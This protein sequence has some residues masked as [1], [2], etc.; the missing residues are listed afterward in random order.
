MKRLT[1]RQA[2][3][4]EFGKRASKDDWQKQALGYSLEIRKFE[5][6]LYWKRATYFWA[7]I[8]ATFAGYFALFGKTEKDASFAALVLACLGAL[9]SKTWVLANRGSKFWQLNWETHVDALEPES[10]GPLYQTVIAAQR[11]DRKSGTEP[12]PFSVSKLN[13]LLSQFVT[14]VWYLLLA[15]TCFTVSVSPVGFAASTLLVVI[16]LYSLFTLS[17]KAQTTF[18]PTV[19][20]FTVRDVSDAENTG[21]DE[22]G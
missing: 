13:Q 5:I 15:Y 21:N 8:A 9:F 3:L 7:F 14:R 17:R 19:M 11:F 22:N 20:D 6:E 2:Y 12:F 1:S 10:I 4:A 18:G 16:T